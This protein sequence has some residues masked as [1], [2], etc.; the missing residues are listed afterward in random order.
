MDRS[1]SWSKPCDSSAGQHSTVEAQER[2]VRCAS[3]SRN[4]ALNSMQS[5]IDLVPLG[6]SFTLGGATR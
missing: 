1:S 3:S 5:M 6:A 4:D 2:E